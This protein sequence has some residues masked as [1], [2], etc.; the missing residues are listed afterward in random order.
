[1]LLHMETIYI[2]SLFILNLIIDYLLLL[3]T[4]RICSARL[5]RGFIALGAAIG[6]AYSVMVVLPFGGFLTGWPCRV[7]AAVM[8]L[9][10]SYWGEKH[11]FR[12]F[13]VFLAVSAAF[14][15]TVYAVSLL[16]GGSGAQTP[17][18]SVS[19]KTLLLSFAVCYAALSLVFR[20]SASRAAREVLPA[21]AELHGERICF[22]VLR[23]TGN[24]LYDPVSGLPVCIAEAETASALFPA[25]HRG[26]FSAED[27]VEMFAELSARGICRF[28][29]IPYS[30][31]GNPGG[32]LPAF[33]PDRLIIGGKV[34][35]ALIAIAPDL[36]AGGEYSAI[37]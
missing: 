17:F 25:E 31:V 32:L 2:D 33:R 11:I 6:A 5:R 27:P 19:P 9:I 22:S 16:G 30:S 23:D 1:M 29:L 15:G 4:G 36:R 20:R 12:L 14:G 3:V 35:P 7:A 8:M 34:C 13:A 28:R 24:G 10:A 37:F 21:E 18:V 26:C